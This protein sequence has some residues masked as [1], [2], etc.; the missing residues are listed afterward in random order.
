MSRRT[1]VIIPSGVAKDIETWSER[2][3]P[4]EGCGLLVGRFDSSTKKSVLRFASLTN[5]LLTNSVNNAPTLPSERQG[6][7]AGRTE[8]VMD[9]AEFN[10]ATLEAEKEGLDVV[11][12]V[13]T[14]PDH[15]ARPS[16]ID[17]SQPFLSQWSNIIVAVHG[18]K[19]LEM[20]SWFRD[21]DTDPF[22]EEDIQVS[23]GAAGV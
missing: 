1:T 10:R 13:H 2:A 3:Y 4:H 17:A 18:G 20:K 14:H 21:S 6:S 22:T 15:P 19:F 12:V 7:G 11:G 8:F 16:A 9:P 5:Q 23:A